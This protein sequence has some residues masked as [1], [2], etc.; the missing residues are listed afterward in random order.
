MKL[1]IDKSHKG[2]KHRVEGSMDEKGPNQDKK[3]K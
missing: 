1:V 3:D 2:N